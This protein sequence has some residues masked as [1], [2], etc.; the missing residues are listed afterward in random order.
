[1]SRRGNAY[2]SI[3]FLVHYWFYG[4]PLVV[5]CSFIIKFGPKQRSCDIQSKNIYVIYEFYTIE[6]TKDIL[7]NDYDILSMENIL[8]NLLIP[9]K[10][11]IKEIKRNVV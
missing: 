6:N 9:T 8:S 10:C 5:V 1:M 2:K 7:S 4:D 11:C 3:I